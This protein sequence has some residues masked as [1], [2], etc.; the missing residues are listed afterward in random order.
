[1]TKSESLMS[2]FHLCITE[3]QSLTGKHLKTPW[4]SPMWVS[5]L[6]LF[7]TVFSLFPFPPPPPQ[8]KSCCTSSMA[9]LGPSWWGTPW[10][11][12]RSWFPVPLAGWTG[13]DSTHTRDFART[14]TAHVISYIYLEP[15]YSSWTD[16]VLHC[17][18]PLPPYSSHPQI[19]FTWVLN[20]P[21]D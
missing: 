8:K 4:K 18:R 16:V 11:H 2:I 10:V 19:P 6:F 13:T 20:L 14:C 5:G 21:V 1:M 3:I 7:P 17:T 9:P 15:S 12:T